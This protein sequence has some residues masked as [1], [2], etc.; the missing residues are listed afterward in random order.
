MRGQIYSEI[1]AKLFHSSRLQA[2]KNIVYMHTMDRCTVQI[3]ALTACTCKFDT[4]VAAFILT[5]FID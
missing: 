2:D 5:L 1:S 4:A 3:S